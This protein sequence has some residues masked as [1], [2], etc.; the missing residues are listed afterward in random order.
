LEK[1]IIPRIEALRE[2][3]G[4][5][6]NVLKA[7]RAS[8]TI[9]EDPLVYVESNMYLLVSHGV[10]WPLVLKMFLIQPKVLLQQTSRLSEIIAEL[11]LMGF[12]PSKYNVLFLLAM[13]TLTVRTKALWQKKLEAYRSFGMSKD[14]VYLAFRMQPHCMEISVEN[15]QK[16]M[17]FYIYKLKLK[18]SA[19]SKHPNLMMFSIQKRI[20]PREY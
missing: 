17:S 4:N 16:S 18:P 13:R 1:S 3:L 12:S 11:K 8:F 19:I 20:V 2:L 5:D 14:E 6:A 15:I 9:L 10:P 7:I